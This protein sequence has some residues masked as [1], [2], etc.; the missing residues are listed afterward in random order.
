MTSFFPRVQAFHG[1][2]LSEF[3]VP[4][5]E[6]VGVAGFEL[7]WGSFVWLIGLVVSRVW[8]LLGSKVEAASC[9]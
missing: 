5:L 3:R 8:S 4:G 9:V 7:R 1:L 6:F 2:K